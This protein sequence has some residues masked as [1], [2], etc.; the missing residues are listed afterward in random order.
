MKA[1]HIAKKLELSD[2][3]EH[4]ARNAVF[5]TLKDHK[6]HFNH[7][8]THCVK[9]VQIRG[10]FWS[11]FPVFGLNTKICEVNLRVPSKYKKMRTRNNSV[12]GHFSRSVPSY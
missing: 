8:V 7:E 4:L 5:I 6:K 10:Y 12:F 2:R 9:S 1:K 3:A 11:V